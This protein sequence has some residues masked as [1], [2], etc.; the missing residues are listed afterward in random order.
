MHRSLARCL[1][2]RG[3]HLV[4][5]L[6]FLSYAL[7]LASGFALGCSAL[8]LR[9]KFFPMSKSFLGLCALVGKSGDKTTRHTAVSADLGLGVN[10]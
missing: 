9:N 2:S 5:A 1:K 6:R 8:V 3:L 7:T 4:L 10:F